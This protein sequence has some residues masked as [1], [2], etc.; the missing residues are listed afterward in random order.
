MSTTRS[1]TWC[2]GLHREGDHALPRPVGARR[3][4]V[5]RRMAGRGP[6]RPARHPPRREVRRRRPGRDYRFYVILNEELARAGASGPM[7][8]LHNDMIGPYL[9]R[10]C[11]PEQRDRWFP[12]YCSGELIAAIA[13][14]EPGAGQRPAGRPHHRGSRRGPLRAERPEDVHLQRAAGRHR[15]RGGT[16]RPGRGPPRDQPAHGGTGHA[17]LHPRPEP[18][19]ARHA[20]AGH[21]G[22]VLHRRRGAGREPAGGGGRRVRRVDA[23]PAAGAGHHRRHRSWPSPNRPS[24]TRWPTASSAAR[25]ASRWASSSTTGSPWP[26]WRPRSQSRASSTDRAITEHCAGRLTNDEAAMVKWWNT[27]LC[28]RVTD[29][30]VQLH[31]GYGYMREYAVGPGLDRLPGAVPSSGGNHRDHERDHRPRPRPVGARSGGWCPA[32]NALPPRMVA[33]EQPSTLSYRRPPNASTSAGGSPAASSGRHRGQETTPGPTS[34]RPS[35]KLAISS[36]CVARTGS[37]RFRCN[38]VWPALADPRQRRWCRR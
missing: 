23:E 19:Q 35:K 12:G 28:N 20:R 32:R 29:R 5:P 2:G 14:T 37:R 6:G 17:R 34:S 25:S 10:L 15:D 18:G 13:M 38:P 1:V 24:P 11:S 7:F 27:E 8:Q 30:C 26:R 4:R 31:G 3:H 33:Q 22:A 9:D 36:G 16:H 21:L